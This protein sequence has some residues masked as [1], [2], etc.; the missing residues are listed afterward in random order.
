MF[1]SLW[2]RSPIY[3]NVLKSVPG[4]DGTTEPTV[5]Y[6]SMNI[7]YIHVLDNPARDTTT[8]R[9]EEAARAVRVSS[10]ETHCSWILMAYMNH[11]HIHRVQRWRNTHLAD[12]TGERD[13]VGL[14]VVLVLDTDD[15]RRRNALFDP[16]HHRGEDVVLSIE[17]ERGRLRYAS[18]CVRRLSSLIAP[19]VSS[20]SLYQNGSI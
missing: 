9:T 20:D 1:R 2:R 8:S 18:E 5:S 11:S 6:G 12:W 13:A 7:S 4:D 19:L 16:A 3:L 15:L 17:R 10:P 14:R